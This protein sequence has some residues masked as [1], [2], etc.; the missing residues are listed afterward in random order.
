MLL[1][2]ETWSKNQDAIA[3]PGYITIG[4]NRTELHRRS[5][6]G[7][8]GIAL[9]VK[10]ELLTTYKVSRTD[11]GIEGILRVNFKHKVSDSSFSVYGVYIPPESSVYAG[12]VDELFEHLVAMLYEADNE[13]FTLLCGDW[14]ARMGKKLDII[15]AIDDVPSRTILDEV[16][17]DHGITLQNFMFQTKT[18][19]L[20]GRI[21]P[22]NNNYTSIS[23]RGKA[24]VDYMLVPHDMLDKVVDFAVIG[25][26]E[27]VEKEGLQDV[28]KG[29]ISDHSVLICNVNVSTH[30]SDDVLVEPNV[31]NVLSNDTVV[32]DTLPRM[33]KKYRKGKIPE[34]FLTEADK[35]NKFMHIIDQLLSDG[36]LQ[37]KLDEVYEELV[38]A[39]HLEMQQFLKIIENTPKSKKSVRHTKKPYWS[40][41]LGELWKVLHE[42][43]KAY[44]HC[45]RGNV[46]YTRLREEFISAQ[47]AF[48]KCLKKEKR[49]FERSRVFNLEKANTENPVEF[50]KF[51]SN[52]G[53]KK[54]T[55]PIWEVYGDDG[56]IVSDK[57]S[58]LN[59]WRDDFR[60][61]L[62]PPTC[63]DPAQLQF[64]QEIRMSNASREKALIEDPAQVNQAI[65]QPFT[66]EEVEKI[67]NKAK[68][69]KACG[70]DGLIADVLKNRCSTSI[71]TKLFNFC[72]SSG[73][74]PTMWSQG[75]ISP[76]PK[77][78]D[79]DP[80][81]PLNFRG[82]S[83][84][85]V[86]GKLYTAAIS[87]RLSAYLEKHHLL[88]NEQNGF[89]S[90]R[91]C[92]DHIYTLNN[93][94]RNRNLLKL[95]TFLTFIDFSKAFDYV[96]H[97]LL[98]HKLLNLNINGPIYHAIKQIYD[99]PTSCVQFDG[100]LTGW[101][102]ITSGVRQGDSLSPT[103]FAIYINDL[104]EEMKNKDTGILV[105]GLR[106]PLLLYADDIVI[107]SENDVKAQEQLDIMT[108]WCK[109]WKMSINAKK[110][111]IVHVRN[112]QRKRS[113]TELSC[114]DQ[115]LKYVPTYKY[116]G[117][118]MHEHT[119]PKNAI[120]TLTSAAS[121]SFGRIVSMFRVLKNMGVKSYETLYHSYVV[122][123]MHYGSAVWG[124]K[125][126]NDTRVLQNRIAR[127]YLGVH[128]F[129]AVCATQLE[130][131]WLSVKYRRWVDIIRYHNRLMDMKAHRL[132]VIIYK[133]DRSL[134]L[135]S[136][137]KEVVHILTY[138]DM[139]HDNADTW[140]KFDLDVV[141]SR[142]K[143][144]YRQ[145]L[146]QEAHTKDKLR[147]FVQVH[148]IKNTKAIV[149]LNLSR[150][151]R[152]MM[153]K[154]KCGVLPLA[155]EIG[156]F[157]NTDIDDRVCR[158]CNEN[159]VEDEVHMTSICTALQSERNIFKAEVKE[160]VNLDNF[161]GI[162]YL[163]RILQ[164]DLLKLTAK[165][166][167]SMMEL[168]RELL[169]VNS[170]EEA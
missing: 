50:W 2:V 147:T 21:S 145:Q 22:L 138:A 110:S 35:V 130:L 36:L 75:I 37:E 106:I 122:P 92:L 14:N 135:D 1:L 159:V 134:K 140:R 115:V 4:N 70:V 155:I 123:I 33:P 109:K 152:S 44:V 137:A 59:K 133:W 128:K 3:I 127:Y 164:P 52:L 13:D 78:K 93:I 88:A 98:F 156:R 10:S 97:D 31:N 34:N 148:D 57:T 90:E 29:R 120:E 38:E 39:Y 105:G 62:T 111:Q 104:V 45:K 113:S 12:N 119:N 96:T 68:S 157:S 80:R 49:H 55:K 87:H 30:E 95:Q 151:Q 81:V 43:E 56:D 101:F 144:L 85:S 9:L 139:L 121:R 146:W 24:I 165:H 46:A 162:A 72:M 112:P 6:K 166:I 28:V 154:L 8:G 66:D 129:T 19:M 149:S 67:I 94:C 91:S 107:L 89:R 99:N 167:V 17:N 18:C 82:I 125:E 118:L 47:R 7:S 161:E 74:I 114:C 79:S 11:D 65:N 25:A 61:L 40:E 15:E 53:P 131:D 142:L 124:Y 132:P 108:T 143:F 86:P 48:D 170:D 102:P 51:I 69:G 76:I 168:R 153:I 71:C 150:I 126:N 100:Q 63:L 54:V 163:Y 136:W 77:C 169:Y 42:K 160:T 103:L 26:T 60:S 16:S 23:H 64:E 73:K 20:N 83:L 84:L 116:L 32:D 41:L 141:E 58:V 158:V 5:R 27:L 117:F